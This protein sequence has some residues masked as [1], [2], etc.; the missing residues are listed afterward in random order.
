MSRIEKL[1]IASSKG[2]LAV[3]VHYPKEGTEKL[4]ILCPGYLD[5]KDYRGLVV[6]AEDLSKKGF[7]VARFNPTGTWDSEGDISDYTMTQYLKD[8]ESVLEFMLD[9]KKYSQVL[10]GGH[11][12]G[13]QMAILFAARD[14]RISMVLGIMPSSGPTLGSKRKEWKESGFDISTR[15]LPG[16]R[17]N[18]IEFKVPF[19]RVLDRDQYDAVKDVGKIKVPIIL[20]AGELD[21]IVPKESVEKLYDNAN[22]IKK[23]V[24]IPEIGHDYRLNESE[25]MIVN[26]EILKQLDSVL[27][28]FH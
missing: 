8:I 9:G 27:K 23:Y 14:R 10:I 18:R 13:G 26:K 20:V 19:S 4:A 3:A 1:K 28:E 12:Q 17:N 25:I 22:Q 21:D 5:S 2:S 11:S 7:T 24:I 6:L 15:D 16:D